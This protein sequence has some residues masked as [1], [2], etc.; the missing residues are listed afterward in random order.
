M[1]SEDGR[2]FETDDALDGRRDQR[3]VSES[4][5]VEIKRGVEEGRVGTERGKHVWDKPKPSLHHAH[6]LVFLWWRSDLG[7]IIFGWLIE[8]KEE[9]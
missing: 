2:H 8:Q 5:A 1:K 7:G 3:C 9:V 4:R 6:L